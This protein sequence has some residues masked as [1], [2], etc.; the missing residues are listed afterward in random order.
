MIRGSRNPWGRCQSLGKR[1]NKHWSLGHMILHA[2]GSHCVMCGGTDFRVDRIKVLIDIERGLLPRSYHLYGRGNTHR[3][4]FVKKQLKTSDL[5]WDWLTKEY[6]PFIAP[7]SWPEVVLAVW[8]SN[9]PT[10]YEFINTMPLRVRGS[11][12]TGHEV[13]LLLCYCYGMSISM[14]EEIT[15]TDRSYL[16][17]MMAAGLED[18]LANF[19][20]IKLWSMHIH[21]SKFPLTLSD[22]DIGM[23]EKINLF[24]LLDTKPLEV[25]PGIAQQLLA[26]GNFWHLWNLGVIPVK[27]SMR[28]M[29]HRNFI[30]PPRG[31]SNHGREANEDVY[32]EI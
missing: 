21:W 7:R 17:R 20:V 30:Y 13:D 12:V 15:Q 14:L 3:L 2:S 8:G 27:R 5:I 4:N 31:D 26:T 1:S 32:E 24:H 19:P 23:I 6:H 16:F 18:I 10:P 22:L 28:A 25:G 29:S 11:T 9:A